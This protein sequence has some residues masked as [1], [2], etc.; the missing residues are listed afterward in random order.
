MNITMPPESADYI[1]ASRSL[2]EANR[3]V[4]EAAAKLQRV[5]SPGYVDA[6][7]LKRAA[8][9][10][11]GEMPSEPRKAGETRIAEAAAELADAYEVRD[12]RKGIL[13]VLKA[14]EEQRVRE[15]LRPAVE[16]EERKIAASLLQIY[17]P[18]RVIEQVKGR[19]VSRDFGFWGMPCKLETDRVFKDEST[20]RASEL[21][22]VVRQASA[23]NYIKLPKELA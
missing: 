6:D 4:S 2:Q 17:E 10:E 18:F 3:L 9:I 15:A 22:Q 14:K 11:R 1:A 5:S 8:A 7:D 16:A 21:A 20:H 23:L 13:G 19:L 12:I